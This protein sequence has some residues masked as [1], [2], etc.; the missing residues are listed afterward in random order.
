[1]ADG[2]LIATQQDEIRRLKDEIFGRPANPEQSRPEIKGTLEALGNEDAMR[3]SH[4]VI[5]QERREYQK[6]AET[7]T[8][9]E[10]RQTVEKLFDDLLK[11]PQ[12]DPRPV[13]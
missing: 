7:F 6:K 11:E 9:Q 1:N 3:A 10:L 12:D 4:A 13:E 2:E 5:L 8:I